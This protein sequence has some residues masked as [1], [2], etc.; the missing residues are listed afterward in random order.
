ME[1]GRQ[2]EIRA[3]QRIDSQNASNPAVQALRL[4]GI[5]EYYFQRHPCCPPDVQRFQDCRR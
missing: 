3:C 4:D 2:G 5:I 1:A